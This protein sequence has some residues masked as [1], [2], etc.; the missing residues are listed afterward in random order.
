M[1]EGEAQVEEVALEEGEAKSSPRA[2]SKK[3]IP[4]IGGVLL[5]QLVVAYFLVAKFFLPP[6]SPPPESPGN[7]PPVEREAIE[8]REQTPPEGPV[9]PGEGAIH[10]LED[11][12]VNPAGTGGNRYLVT[13]IAFE[14]DPKN[15]KLAKEIETKEPLLRD[16]II[17][18][19]S[20]K[21]I[22]ELI[23]V[24]RRDSLRQEVL[25]VVNQELEEG[26]V[27]WVYFTKYVLQ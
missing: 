1:K 7:N 9:K 23:D 5:V 10:I 22:P 12:I 19:L 24:S 3:K 4:L 11:V 25:Q 14:V 16:R 13:S 8:D 21:G 17:T 6:M 18:L 27:F 20:S 2:W 15:K 26:K